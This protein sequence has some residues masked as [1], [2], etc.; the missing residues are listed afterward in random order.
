[1]LAVQ[2]VIDNAADSATGSIADAVSNMQTIVVA[3]HNAGKV[4]EIIAALDLPDTRFLSLADLGL[5][6]EAAEVAKS[7]AGNAWIKAGFVFSRTRQATLADDSGL[8]V[9]ALDGLPGVRS[10][11]YAGERASDAE[12][13]EKLLQA[14]QELPDEQRRARFVCE[15]AYVAADGSQLSARGVCEG[16]IAREPR[17]GGGFGYDPVFIP[18]NPGDGRTMAELS[19]DEKSAISHRGLALRQ[20]RDKLAACRGAAP[21]VALA[22]FDFDGTLLAVASPVRL[23]FRLLRLQMMPLSVGFQVFWWAIRYK[24]HLAVNQD[25]VRRYIYSAFAKTPA[26]VARRLMVK[27]Y[28]DKLKARLRPKGM[29]E[30]EWQRGAGRKIILISASFEPILG[31]L[32][33]ELRADFFIST[34]MEVVDGRYTGQV[35]AVPPEGIYK[36]LHLQHKADAVYGEG[37]WYL[38]YAFGDHF[39][40]AYLLSLALHPVVVSPDRGLAATARELSW[41]IADWD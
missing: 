1:L 23:V 33:A 20:L 2:A 14:M 32:A 25:Q 37:N 36:L 39:N 11:R 40:D 28:Y 17:G 24:L 41:E 9:D 31:V 5:T 8:E 4:P 22:A 38:D 12:N 7:L 6:D 30:V 16:R 13:L 29:Q 26:E 18:D 35:A 21:R 3:T 27:L 34:E 19:P 15:I 10:A